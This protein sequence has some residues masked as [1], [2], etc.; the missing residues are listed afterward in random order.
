MVNPMTRL[1]AALTIAVFSVTGLPVADASEFG[2]SVTFS[3]AE[4]RIINAWYDDHGSTKN[5]KAGKGG[6]NGL[7]PGIAKNLTRG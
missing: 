2:V 7:P 1:I 6:R 5:R 3:D 4:V